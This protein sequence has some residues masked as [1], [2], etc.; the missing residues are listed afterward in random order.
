MCG[1]ILSHSLLSYIN[2]SVDI[3][4]KF[5][6]IDVGSMLIR[7]MI[8]LNVIAIWLGNGWIHIQKCL[9]MCVL[10]YIIYK[11]SSILNSTK[12]FI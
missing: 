2:G 9:T 1:F 3:M 4:S 6:T 11:N 8:F 12:G 10:K 5:Q 7:V